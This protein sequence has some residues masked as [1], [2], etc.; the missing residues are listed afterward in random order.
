MDRRPVGC[1]ALNRQRSRIRWA[2]SA[3]DRSPI[4][5]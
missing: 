1:P 4:Q 5:M 3:G 2:M